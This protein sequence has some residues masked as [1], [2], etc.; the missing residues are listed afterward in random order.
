MGGDG[1]SE[2]LYDTLGRTFAE[3]GADG[4]II[5]TLLLLDRHFAG[6][7]FRCDRFQAILLAGKQV[8]EFFGE[9]GVSLKLVSLEETEKQE[10]A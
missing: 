3:L 6:Q 8:V 5:R 9:N 4:P 2:A 10:A 7:K 1:R